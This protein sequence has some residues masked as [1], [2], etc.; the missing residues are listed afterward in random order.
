MPIVTLRNGRKA[1]IIVGKYADNKIN[2]E[3]KRV[4]KTYK[5]MRF[6]S[7]NGCR[8]QKGG[9]VGELLQGIT[10]IIPSIMEFI[11]NIVKP[12]KETKEEYEQRIR[13]S[14]GYK[15]WTRLSSGR[16]ALQDPFTN[17]IYTDDN[18][19]PL[20][21]SQNQWLQLR[22]LENNNNPTFG[23]K[24]YNGEGIVDGV[25]NGVKDAGTW[26]WDNVLKPKQD[27]SPTHGF[28]LPNGQF[29]TGR[30]GGRSGGKFAPPPAGV[31]LKD[32]YMDR[33]DT[34]TVQ[35]DPKN[36]F[37]LPFSINRTNLQP[38]I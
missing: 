36:Y 19:Q 35:F 8:K 21:I 29:I 1:E 7:G 15:Q 20:I 14:V 16:Y 5:R 23:Y 2:R 22:A 18:D 11:N 30:V 4:G 38:I 12:K 25:L 13:E 32:Y 6:I 17:E 9:F 37:G 10:S 27:Y 24:K 34:P 26:L 28:K 33:T 31:K 3:L